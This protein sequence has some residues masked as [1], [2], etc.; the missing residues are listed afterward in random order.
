[1]IEKF[2]DRHTNRLVFSGSESNADFW[3]KHWDKYQFEKLYSGH[4]S[5]FDYVIKTT[6]RYLK[7]GSQLLEGGCGMG[8]QVFKL[9]HAGFR[10]TGIDYAEETVKKVNAL[11]PELDVRFGDIRNLE[12]SENRFDG[13][14]SFGVIE[15]FYQGYEDVM[16]EM[17]RVIKPDGYLFITFP[18]MCKLRRI[19]AKKN[20]YQPWSEDQD[21]IKS[22]YQFAL[23]KKDVIKSFR[24]SGFEYLNQKHLAALKGLKDEIGFMKKPLQRI[25]DGRSFLA[26][27]LSKLIS[28]PVTRFSSHSILLIFRLKK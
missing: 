18:H 28:I 8:Q 20:K 14:W 3:D 23:Y 12:F 26:L 24:S 22:F 21:K 11:K 4:Q 10:V 16:K 2:F 5:P 13:Y 25:F 27:S 7:P 19:K 15:H 17:L 1:M 9:Q 6:K